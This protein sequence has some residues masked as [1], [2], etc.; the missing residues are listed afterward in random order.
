M[1]VSILQIW[2]WLFIGH[3]MA[4]IIASS[5][6]LEK[7]PRLARY[8]APALHA[9]VTA[10]ATGYIGLGIVDWLINHLAHDI[11]DTKRRWIGLTAKMII[12]IV[13]IIVA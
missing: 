12:G 11:S 5:A 4:E 3:A 2:F 1:I 9:G 13:A 6:F 7:H 8:Y 10:Y